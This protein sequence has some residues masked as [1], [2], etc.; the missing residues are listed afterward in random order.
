MENADEWLWLH[1]YMS[2]KKG[3]PVL[4]CASHD[5]IQWAMTKLCCRVK[6]V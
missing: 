4:E 6:Y 2:G 5:C 1:K 3:V